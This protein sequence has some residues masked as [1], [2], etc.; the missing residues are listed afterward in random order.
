MSRP[1]AG[2]SHRH[3]KRGHAGVRVASMNGSKPYGPSGQPR[4]RT[5]RPQRRIGPAMRIWFA[6]ISQ[7]LRAAVVL[8]RSGVGRREGVE[9][10]PSAV[11]LT[12]CCAR[13]RAQSGVLRVA[14][15]RSEKSS[16]HETIHRD[17]DTRLDGVQGNSL[18]LDS[19][20]FGDLPLQSFNLGWECD[21]P[22]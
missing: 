12:R 17:T 20:R 6:D 11:Y 15:P 10:S 3:Q 18:H 2:Q 19:P 21:C 7:M 14:D 9:R 4:L 8:G 13:G 22:D 16:Q 5:P 1:V